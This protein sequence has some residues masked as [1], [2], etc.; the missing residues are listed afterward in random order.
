[1]LIMH[2]SSHGNRSS[3]SSKKVNKLI[4]EYY[5]FDLPVK[6]KYRDRYSK[7]YSNFNMMTRHKTLWHFNFN[8]DDA[9]CNVLAN[10]ASIKAIDSFHTVSIITDGL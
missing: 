10:H 7:E 2:R 1:M 4:K 3:S 5:Y 9:E 8:K 6:W